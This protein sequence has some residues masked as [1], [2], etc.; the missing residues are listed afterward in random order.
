[1]SRSPSAITTTAGTGSLNAITS[2]LATNG[3]R[4]TDRR[5]GAREPVDIA[6]TDGALCFNNNS[7]AKRLRIG[8]IG[9]LLEAGDVPRDST[10]PKSLQSFIPPIP[11][12]FLLFLLLLFL[13]AFSVLRLAD[14]GKRC[15]P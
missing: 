8:G 10:A 3:V 6:S 1:M 9:G 14:V 5:V 7:T 11:Q 2:A 15:P 12:S 4:F 13:L